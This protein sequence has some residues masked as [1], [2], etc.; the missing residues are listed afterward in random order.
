[1]AK[2]DPPPEPRLYLVSPG[3]CPPDRLERALDAGD[4][5]AV[6][7]RDARPDSAK[8][9]ELTQA[10]D[11]AALVEN[12]ADLAG[13]LGADGVHLGP[14]GRV[15]AVRRQLAEDAIVGAFCGRSRHTGMLAGEAGADY[16]AFDATPGANEPEGEPGVLAWWQTMMEL[17]CVAMGEI[18]LADVGAL[19]AAGADFVALENAV[20]DHPDGPAA[21]VA[22]ANRRLAEPAG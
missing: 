5:A 18:P 16:I 20:W 11:V 3:D 2:T 17:P 19:V 22:E 10:R 21:A 1:M 9:V 14:G 13:R 6:L 15:K 8:L 4:V 7:I 12:D